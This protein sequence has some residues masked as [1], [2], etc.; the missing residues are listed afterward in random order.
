MIWAILIILGIP[1]WLIAIALIGLLRG[2]S[3]VK[4]LPGS[5]DCKVRLVA[6]DDAGPPFSRYLARAQWV[7]DVIVVYG[8]SP[9]H[10]AS[11]PY[12]VTELLDG[13]VAPTPNSQL[14]KFGQ[15]VVLR[16][17]CDAGEIIEVACSQSSVEAALGPF[18]DELTVLTPGAVGSQPANTRSR[19]AHPLM[20]H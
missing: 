19:D 1:L 5:F 2:R 7:H 15:P 11:T 16:L 17:R 8:G 9:F 13:P 6:P 10:A 18:A 20:P 3:R 12:G 4:A 14:K